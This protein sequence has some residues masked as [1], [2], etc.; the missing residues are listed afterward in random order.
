MTP[1]LPQQ[2]HV[3][4][5]DTLEQMMAL[6]F[7]GDVMFMKEPGRMCPEALWPI[8]MGL[9]FRGA[10]EADATADVMLGGS[11]VDGR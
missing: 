5:A 3:V 9:G 8:G 1:P 4:W 7:G 6:S 10:E 2:D 11:T